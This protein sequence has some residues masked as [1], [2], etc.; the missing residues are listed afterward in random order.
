MVSRKCIFIGGA[1]GVGKSSMCARYCEELNIGHYTASNLIKK[2]RNVDEQHY[3]EV[4][5]T[6]KNQDALL[7][8]MEQFISHECY[9]LDGH[10]VIKTTGGLISRIP[11]K[12][13]ESIRPIGIVIVTG[14]PAQSSIRLKLRDGKDW[15]S[16]DLYDIQ[17]SELEHA[18]TVADA[19]GL[20]LNITPSTDYEYFKTTLD[21]LLNQ[22][23]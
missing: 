14:D 7:S 15:L 17:N 10:F 22:S 6:Q 18:K 5:D 12:T 23:G 1:Y 11:L 13:Y 16:S 21:R 2:L 19:L 9:L 20:I 8:A 3:K 4:V